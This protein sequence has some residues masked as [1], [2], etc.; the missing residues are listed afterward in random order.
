MF[1]TDV[2]PFSPTKAAGITGSQPYRDANGALVAVLGADVGS[3]A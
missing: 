3:K 1:R 2:Y